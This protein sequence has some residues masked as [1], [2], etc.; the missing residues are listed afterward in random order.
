MSFA[1]AAA[2]LL[3]TAGSSSSGESVLAVEMPPLLATTGET[4]AVAGTSGSLAVAQVA[5]SDSAAGVVFIDPVIGGE[6][7]SPFEPFLL[8]ARRF[9]RLPLDPTDPAALVM[10]SPGA[11]DGGDLG[12]AHPSLSGGTGFENRW[13]V[14]GFEVSDPGVS[15]FGP[16]SSEYG[17]LGWSFPLA[18]VDRLAVADVALDPARGGAGGG[19]VDLVLPSGGDRFAMGA[20]LALRPGFAEST[21]RNPPGSALRSGHEAVEDGMV[22][23]SGP[24]VREKVWFF[25]GAGFAAGTRGYSARGGFPLER[26]GN[27]TLRREHIPHVAKLVWTPARG[28][29]FDVLWLG[30]R[31][32]GPFGLQRPDDLLASSAMGFSALRFNSELEGLRWQGYFPTGTDVDASVSRTATSFERVISDSADRHQLV[33]DHVNGT[34]GGGIGGYERSRHAEAVRVNVVARQTL[35]GAGVHHLRA[36]AGVETLSLRVRDDRGG[37]HIGSFLDE[38]GVEHDYTTGLSYEI[39]QADDASLVY[40]VIRGGWGDP[41]VRSGSQTTSAFVEDRWTPHARVSIVAALRVEE[42]ALHGGGAGATRYAFPAI[43]TPRASVEWAP[44]RDGRLAAGLEGGRV[45][46]PLPL[47]IANGRMSGGR[48]VSR[49]DYIS[50]NFSAGNQIPDG[51]VPVDGDSAHLGTA[52][53]RGVPV[54]SGTQLPY[55]DEVA[56]AIRWHPS[57]KWRADARIIRRRLGRIVEDVATSETLEEAQGAPGIDFDPA[58]TNPEARRDY[59]AIE[60]S[61]RGTLGKLDVLASWRLARLFGNYEGAWASD[62]PR[63]GFF[64]FDFPNDTPLATD[65]NAGRLPLDRMHVVR[66]AGTYETPF[67]V[68]VAAIAWLRTGR[69]RTEWVE[70][71][72]YGERWFLPRGGWG[73][74]GREP[75]TA[76]LDVRASWATAVGALRLVTALDVLNV[77]DSQTVERASPWR[78]GPD[79]AS[80]GEPLEFAPPRSVRLTVSAAY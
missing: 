4:A 55:Y 31:G 22:Q 47:E 72:V 14:D 18:W 51:T 59:D 45:A 1:F 27:E 61:V 34:S 53:Q 19:T 2:W 37:A 33:L 26:L 75:G 3:T 23:A 52:E 58:I 7:G 41:V 57:A 49:V 69:A 16:W 80:F 79:A 66:L 38:D 67:D 15:S 63:H 73:E 71:P 35:D 50:S 54:R 40:R 9:S 43:V 77:F 20:T 64:A 10:L 11:T 76:S 28:Q 60:L 46:L 78:E 8:D 13:H 32:G 12:R 30:E 68:D 56:A 62:Q 29:T 6:F 74:D 48:N 42:T 39:L 5:A 25:G 21:R 65:G 36:G 17:A 44:L 24:I 70:H